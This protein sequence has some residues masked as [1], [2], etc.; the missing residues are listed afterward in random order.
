MSKNL[1]NRGVQEGRIETTEGIET[2]WK[3]SDEISEWVKKL[4][5]EYDRKA[6][7]RQR[8]GDSEEY[9]EN[10]NEMN[11]TAIKQSLKVGENIK[12]L[13]SKVFGWGGIRT[14]MMSLER[15]RG[16]AFEALGELISDYEKGNLKKIETLMENFSITP[17][18]LKSVLDL[19]KIGKEGIKK[20]LLNS[21]TDYAEEL[22][23]FCGVSHDFI[24]YCK[25]E[26]LYFPMKAG[27]ENVVEKAIKDLGLSPE[28]VNDVRLKIKEELTREQENEANKRAAKLEDQGKID[29]LRKLIKIF[30]NKMENFILVMSKISTL[31][32]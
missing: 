32:G 31:D 13:L 1:E 15:F 21:H 28:D 24:L 3:C 8:T 25:K 22:A 23:E 14:Q 7:I 5:E 9:S 11:V 17:E 30:L 10:V 27:D 16:V 19:E 12:E 2:E 26:I 29:G 18:E 4:Q 20:A 6:N